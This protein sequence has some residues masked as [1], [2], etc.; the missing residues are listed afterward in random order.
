MFVLGFQIP[1]RTNSGLL[2][3]GVVEDVSVL[4]LAAGLIQQWT[5]VFG[6]LWEGIY[7]LS[8]FQVTAI[9]CLLC[10]FLAAHQVHRVHPSVLV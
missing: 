1:S 2:G 10:P 8:A 4:G 3:H 6:G 9:P 7:F 5:R